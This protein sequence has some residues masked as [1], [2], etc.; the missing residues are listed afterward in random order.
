MKFQTS[1][2]ADNRHR[3]GRCDWC[4]K[5]ATDLRDARDYE[6]GMSGRVY[7]VCGGCIKA[8]NDEIERD[9]AEYDNGWD[10]YDDYGDER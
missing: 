1:Q 2:V 6:E 3:K 10:D 7:R 8:Q 4:A 5:D 9:L